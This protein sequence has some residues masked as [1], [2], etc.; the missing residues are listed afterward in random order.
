MEPVKGTG[1]LAW[2]VVLTIA[3]VGMLFIVI[4]A[5]SQDNAVTSVDGDRSIRSHY[6]DGE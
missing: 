2:I 6:F 5:F 4:S 1:A 3:A